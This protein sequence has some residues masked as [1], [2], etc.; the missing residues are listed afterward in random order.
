MT[1]AD[2]FVVDEFAFARDEDARCVGPLL[3]AAAGDLRKVQGWLPPGPARAA[4]PRGAVRPRRGGIAMAVALSAALRAALRA[5]P[6]EE[7]C[8]ATDEI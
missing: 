7:P 5:A 8:W 1:A 3:R 6:A 2:A 4:L